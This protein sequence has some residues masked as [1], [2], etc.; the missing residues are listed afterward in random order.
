MGQKGGGASNEWDSGKGSGPICR[1][2]ERQALV[3]SGPVTRAGRDM[4]Q[5]R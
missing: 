3:Y 1:R 5:P 4:G 2:G